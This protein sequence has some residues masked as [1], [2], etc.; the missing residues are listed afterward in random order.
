MVVCLSHFKY[1]P[2]GRSRVGIII[3]TTLM[4]DKTWISS[5][6]VVIYRRCFSG[7]FVVDVQEE[8]IPGLCEVH[9]SI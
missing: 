7:G 6:Q 3:S 4:V 1:W 9:D 2:D 5:L 8:I